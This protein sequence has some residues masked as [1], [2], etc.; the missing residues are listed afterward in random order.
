MQKILLAAL[1]V[2]GATS[3]VL[4]DDRGV[5]APASSAGVT[6]YFET[7]ISGFRSEIDW[8]HTYELGNTDEEDQFA[9]EGGLRLAVPVAP[10]FA[11]QLDGWTYGNTSDIYSCDWDED[12]CGDW[13][14]QD[15]AYGGALHLAYKLDGAVVGGMVSVGSTAY[16]LSNFYATVGL[17]GAVTVD[18]FR[19]YGQIGYTRGMTDEVADDN[20]EHVY[21]VGGVTYYLDPNMSVSGG[22]GVMRYSWDDWP[23]GTEDGLTWSVRI[24]KKLED[25]P[26]SLFAAYE[27]WAWR[28]DRPEVEYEWDGSSHGVKAGLRV[29]F[30]DGSN[31]LQERDNAV[32]FRD[33]NGAYGAGY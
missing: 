25:T 14:D 8:G 27:G 1:A 31:T 10:Q 20:N 22:I 23:A 28:G 13:T 2:A 24:E 7:A 30:G 18:R 19:L 29:A 15:Q 4:A 9:L 32:P 33:V 16:G 21:A 5:V 17:E 26:I 11:L 12:E 3:A 6:G